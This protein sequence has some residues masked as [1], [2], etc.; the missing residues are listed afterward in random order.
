MTTK[1]SIVRALSTVSLLASVT[2]LLDFYIYR[3]SKSICNTSSCEHIASWEFFRYWNSRKWPCCSPWSVWIHMPWPQL[4]DG[5]QL[6]LAQG[7]DHIT[8]FLFLTV[9]C[10]MSEGRA[11]RRILEDTALGSCL[12]KVGQECWKPRKMGSLNL[13]LDGG[14][15]PYFSVVIMWQGDTWEELVFEGESESL[16]QICRFQKYV[17]LQGMRFMR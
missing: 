7:R 15:E 11:Q 4:W 2:H 3:T 5:P 17:I 14:S 16:V 8:L 10:W 13:V 1:N 6:W 9:A 12:R